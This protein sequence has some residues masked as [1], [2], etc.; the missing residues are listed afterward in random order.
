VRKAALR[1]A[2]VNFLAT[3]AQECH[4]PVGRQVVVP[5]SELATELAGLLQA[6]VARSGQPAPGPIAALVARGKASDAQRE[7]VDALGSGRGAIILGAVAMRHTRYADLRA[8]AAAL[9]SLTGA[10]LGYLPDGGNAAG[11]AL[12]GALPHRLPGGRPDPQPG[13]H[14]RQMLESPLAA[15]LMFGAIEPEHDLGTGG[16]KA[17]NGAQLIAITPFAGASL[18]ASAQVLLPM[19]TFAETSGTYVNAEGR[20]QETRGCALPVGEARPGWK[21]LRVL[22]NLLDLDGFDYGSSTDILQELRRQIGEVAY[23][24]RF[25]SRRAIDLGRGGTT[26]EVAIYQSDAIVRR[27][28]PLQ[29]TRAGRAAAAAG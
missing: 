28:M 16:S 10:T 5:A 26:S 9:A 3:A 17:L 1:G 23:D 14:V 7:I 27:A 8:A 15:C 13:M 2:R 12:A 19:G 18:M 11:A 21:I 25:N 6:A 22:G 29:R 24:G 4:F 20:W